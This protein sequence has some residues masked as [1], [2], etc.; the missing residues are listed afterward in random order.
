MRL[1]LLFFHSQLNRAD[2]HGSLG[3][4][5]NSPKLFPRER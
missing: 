4:A 2:G 1:E 3:D 5:I